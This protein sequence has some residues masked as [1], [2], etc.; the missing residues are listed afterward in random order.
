[1]QTTVKVFVITVEVLLLLFFNSDDEVDRQ[2][3]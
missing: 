2:N 1:M 3:I